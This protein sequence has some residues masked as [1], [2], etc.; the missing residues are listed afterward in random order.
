MSNRLANHSSPLTRAFAV[1]SHAARGKCDI[2][3]RLQAMR[4]VAISLC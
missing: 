2:P 3:P 1:L 4:A